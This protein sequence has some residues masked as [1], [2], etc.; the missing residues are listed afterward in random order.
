MKYLLLVSFVLQTALYAISPADLEKINQRNNMII[1]QDKE[2]QA[3]KK[4]QETSDT[5]VVDTDTYALTSE[6]L[7]NANCFTINQFIF[8][9]TKVLTEE[10]LRPIINLYQHRCLGQAHISNLLK[11]IN[12]IYIKKG[13]ITSRAYLKGQDLS[14]GV[15]HI[16]LFEGK[17]ENIFYNGKQSYETLTAFPHLQ[18]KL[19][20][21]RD[22]EMGLDQLNR[23]PRNEATL[24]LQAGTK[25]GYSLINILNKE[26]KILSGS[27]SVNSTGIE[28]TGKGQGTAQLYADNLFHLN[29]Q[30]SLN[31]NGSLEQLEEKRSQGYSID[32]S[33][34]YGYFLF[35]AGYREFLYR[36]TIYGEN[37]NYISSGASVDY[38][39]NL[40]Y[41]FY[42]DAN[43]ILK[44]NIGLTFKQN[45]N[46]IA[47]ELIQ[48]SSTKLTVGNIG[49]NAAYTFDNSQ[50]NVNFT[51]HQG[52]KLFDPVLNSYHAYKKAQFT[53]YTLDASLN[54]S[55]TMYK[56]PFSL[57]ST[58]SG[59][60]S[61]DKLYSPELIS[62]GGLY[63][64]RGF[65]YMG[66][67]GEIGAYSH[68]DLTY[69]HTMKLFGKGMQLSP[70]LG[71][72]M[73][74]VE[75]DK[76]IYKYMVGSG[77]GIKINYLKASLSF[78]FGAPLF[79]YEPIAE[80]N[81]TSSFSLSYQF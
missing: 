45:L 29:S 69:T 63:T 44:S 70:Y 20:N 51:V 42:R 4:R 74:V 60:Y 65:S 22:I 55:F 77:F 11:R 53:K 28:T 21:L 15:L 27:L 31:V 6:E 10:D 2:R 41:T 67:Y 68:N 56:M 25:E 50:L 71:F 80:E 17:L 38:H 1:L 30:L 79:A 32:W 13:Y 24:N 47:N 12:N 75:Y 54:T 26:K 40:D 46:F 36:S 33:I 16:Y 64:V 43:L 59:Q 34:P 5:Y 35:S 14:T 48:T 49:V 52:L 9:N 73:G 23:L 72:D 37:S 3:Y 58:L 66:Y 61:N 62:I 78:D 19:L 7:V 39:T 81:Y 57:S 8:H 76:D 18:E